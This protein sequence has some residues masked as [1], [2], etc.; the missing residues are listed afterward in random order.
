MRTLCPA[1]SAISPL[2]S[3]AKSAA[4]STP[5]KLVIGADGAKSKVGRA[6]VPGADKVPLVFAYHEITSR[7]ATTAPRCVPSCTSWM[8]QP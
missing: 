7:R 3:I 4:G 6:E 2:L 8:S 1:T 5:T